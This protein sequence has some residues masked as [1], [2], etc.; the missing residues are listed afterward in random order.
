MF[1]I[2]LN[3]YD[4]IFIRTQSFTRHAKVEFTEMISKSL[5]YYAP[6]ALHINMHI[7]NTILKVLLIS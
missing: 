2:L 1:F 5:E 7:I 3:T 6:F 4:F